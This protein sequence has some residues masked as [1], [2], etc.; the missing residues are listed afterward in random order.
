MDTITELA[1]VRAMADLGGLGI[2]HRYACWDKQLGWLRELAKDDVPFGFSIGVKDDA[3]L[4]A[5]TARDHGASLIVIDVAHGH[6][7]SVMQLLE[8]LKD[9]DIG[10]V[11]AG[12]IATARAA[13]DLINTGADAL[14]VGIGP[15]SQCTTRLQTGVGYPQ[16][17]AIREVAV[18]AKGEAR[19]CADGGIR[20]PGDIV[21]AL[22]AGANTAMLGRLFAGTDETP[23]DV[24]RGPDGPVKQYRG[25]ASIEAK[26]DAGLTVNHI[27]G[28][29][30]FVPY[31]GPVSNTFHQLCDGVRSGMSYV[32]A[33]T[34][35]E[36][37]DNSFFVVV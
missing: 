35:D 4:K 37:T 30:S 20:Y 23:G 24:M 36:L 3:A 2:L 25:M 22:A 6:H 14:K 34:L 28:K 27:E 8:T 15:G 12:N 21:K 31:I 11:M 26:Q 1:M 17:L 29:A 7:T 19:V 10:P 5:R 33:R 18:E 16:L 13:R 32:G 9:Q